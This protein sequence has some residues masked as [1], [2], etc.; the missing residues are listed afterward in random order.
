MDNSFKTIFLNLLLIFF[1]IR[2]VR[3]VKKETTPK[4]RPVQPRNPSHGETLST[5]KNT[6]AHHPQT[7]YQSHYVPVYNQKEEIE[8]GISAS[9]SEQANESI[10]NILIEETE[11]GANPSLDVRNTDEIKR[12]IIYS[13]ILG[14]KYE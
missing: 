7:V 3:S 11:A 13:E 12:A 1:V 5:Q 9:P 8:T 6:P 4:Q 10:E 2:I 14:R